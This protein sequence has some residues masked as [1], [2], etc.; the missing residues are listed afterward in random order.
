MTSRQ[1]HQ[2]SVPPGSTVLLPLGRWSTVVDGLRRAADWT[3]NDIDC[4]DCQRE[5]VCDLHA[6]DQAAIRRWR[7]LASRI[8]TATLAHHGTGQR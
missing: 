4:E 1:E 7:E 2:R 3:E 8:E 6:E 5:R